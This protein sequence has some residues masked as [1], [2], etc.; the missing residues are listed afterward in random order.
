[1]PLSTLPGKPF[2]HYSTA[3]LS[4]LLRQMHP[5]TPIRTHTCSMQSTR[6]ITVVAGVAAPPAA[7][8]GVAPARA[9][10]KSLG[11]KLPGV[12]AALKGTRL[13]RAEAAPGVVGA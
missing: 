9:D 13:L 11:W 1:M 4:G 7:A 6:T 10:M 3:C 5:A 12:V 2:L 8:V